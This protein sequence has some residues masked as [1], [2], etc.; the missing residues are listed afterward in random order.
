MGLTLQP[1]MRSYLLYNNKDDVAYQKAV[2]NKKPT[3]LLVKNALACVGRRELTGN[4][5]GL[6]VEL[7]Q[8]TVNGV[9]EN[10]AYCIAGG[11]TMIAGAQE[12]TGIVS[13]ILN[14]E[15]CMTCWRG[16]SPKMKVSRGQLRPGDCVIW[17]HLGTDNGHF[18]IVIWAF[19]DYMT[20]V[21]FNT[22]YGTNKGQI[23]R[24]GG[25]VYLTKRSYGMEGDM[26][27]QGFIRPFEDA[28]SGDDFSDIK[29]HMERIK[30]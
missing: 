11:M 24:E 5:D 21:E 6:F 4:N 7:L 17:N 30:N 27:P 10:E 15:H 18:G 2:A 26:Q 13:K 20:L 29:A 1:K 3:V 23:V 8:M 19:D 14:S 9:A 22:T 25:G 16:T 28:L 12:E